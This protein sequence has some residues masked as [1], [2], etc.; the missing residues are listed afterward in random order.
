MKFIITGGSGH[1][2]RPLSLT[3]LKEGHDVT[4]IGRNADHLN[5][6]TS[7]GAKAAIG[8]VED[9]TFLTRIFSQG[10]DA[11]YTMVPPKWDAKDWKGY[12]HS[13]GKNY[14]SAIRK[15]GISHVVNLS[16]V[17]AHMPDGC[18]PVT[19]L[20]RVEKAMDEL[21]DVHIL[22]LRP[23][24]FYENLLG[25]IPMIKQLNVI[26]ANFGRSTAEI[27]MAEPEDIASVAAEAL[28]KLDFKGHT[29]RYIA[30]DER[31][32]GDI[33]AVLGA[34]IGKPD[35]RW[36]EFSDEQALQGMKQSGL[37]EEIALNYVEMGRAL[38]DGE[39][40]EDYW[41]HHPNKLG[42]TKLE[43]FAKVF[44]EAYEAG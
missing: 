33:A 39:M 5:E 19:G 8:S 3:L 14:V 21:A 7:N 4:V 22:H 26:G 40:Y 29:V 17:G 32:M 18:G 36:V 1:I 12:I 6:L 16:S 13:I 27:I 43:G 24:Y 11:V 44:A 41:P 15:S 34:A 37:A 9:E 25:N 42:S 31:Q 20:H 23:G 38:R 35:L 28:T 30:S 10:A 2:S